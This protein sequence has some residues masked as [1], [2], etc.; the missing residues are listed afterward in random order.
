MKELFSQPIQLWF[1]LFPH[2]FGFEQRGISSDSF[3]LASAEPF[4]VI[5][6]WVDLEHICPIYLWVKAPD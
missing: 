4:E 3:G 6:G 5:P 2:V 1:E